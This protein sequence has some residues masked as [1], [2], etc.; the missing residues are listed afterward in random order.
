MWMPSA[1]V[2]SAATR[3]LQPTPDITLTIPSTA[4]HA[5]TVSAYDAVSDSF[6]AFSGRGFTWDTKMEK[7]DLAAPG[8][9]ITSCAPGGGYAVRTGTSM[10]APFV[11]GSC[12]ALMQWGIID[13]ND[14]FLYGEKMKAYLRKG[15]RRLPVFRQY[16]N[17]QIGWGALCLRN[18][19][20]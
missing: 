14:P 11:T 15:A 13:G 20:P 6:A 16:P 9:D 7:P 19:L 8:V 17:P 5:L 3:F 10:A 1:A 12:A 18:S 4:R 2:R